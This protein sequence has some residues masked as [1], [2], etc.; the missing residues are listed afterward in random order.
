MNMEK[1]DWKKTHR[2]IMHAIK[3]GIEKSGTLSRWAQR[4]HARCLGG[5]S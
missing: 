5:H 3:V 1:G 2:E 4:D